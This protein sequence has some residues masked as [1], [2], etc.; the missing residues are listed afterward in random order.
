MPENVQLFIEMFAGR[1]NDLL[2]R[3][4]LPSDATLLLNEQFVIVA[5][6]VVPVDPTPVNTLIAPP[7][8]LDVAILFEKL[9]LSTVIEE[10]RPTP[11][12]PP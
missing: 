7:F 10:P 8:P 12:A 6:A 9:Q 1:E 11:I 5:E 2:A 3:I 4:S